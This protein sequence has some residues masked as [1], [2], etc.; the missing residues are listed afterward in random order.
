VLVDFDGTVI[1]GDSFFRF[2]WHAYGPWGRFLR[3][4]KALLPLMRYRLGGWDAHRAKEAIFGIFF[5]GWSRARFEAY[6]QWFA[7]SVLPRM[8]RPAAVKALAA[9]LERGD[10]VWL[11]SASPEPYLRAWA[12][13]KGIRVMA[14][15]VAYD[16][17]GRLTG[18]FASANCRGN[19]KVRR[20]QARLD[21]SRYS[22]ITAY[23]DSLE[24]RPMLALAHHAYYRPFRDK[25]D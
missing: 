2:L 13:P 24:D 9:H 21:L 4:G 5:G 8:E 12:E 7:A 18:R 22:D 3:F 6:C 11:V 20:I 15:A 17:N 1:K 25:A 19:E 10:E 16:A 23:G 14:T